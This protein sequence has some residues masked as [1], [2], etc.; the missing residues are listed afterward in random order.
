MPEI[1]H[2]KM[3]FPALFMQIADRRRKDAD[4]DEICVDLETLAGFLQG[5]KALLE[6]QARQDLMDSIRGLE[7]E[8]SAL[9]VQQ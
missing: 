7:N 8:I 4:L 9:L 1:D 5:E 2:I 3:R 6:P